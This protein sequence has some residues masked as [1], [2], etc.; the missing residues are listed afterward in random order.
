M[1]FCKEMKTITNA[2]LAFSM[3]G[4]NLAMAQN[5]DNINRSASLVSRI[6]NSK[7]LVKWIMS[8]G[9]TFDEVKVTGTEGNWAEI[10]YTVITWSPPP[11]QRIVRR[12]GDEAPEVVPAKTERKRCWVNIDLVARIMATTGESDNKKSNRVPVTD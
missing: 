3:L 12:N 10:E 6:S 9:F 11:Q 8:D 7:D 1:T 4:I 2:L 5:E